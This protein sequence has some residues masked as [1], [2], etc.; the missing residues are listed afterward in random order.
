[1][2][3]LTRRDYRGPFGDMVDWLEAPW[4]MLRPAT[5]HL[6]RVEDL[7]KDGSYVVRAELPGIDPEKDVEVTVARGHPDDQGRAARRGD[8][9]APLRVPLRQLHPQRDAA[10]AAPTRS[11]STPST[12]T[13]SWK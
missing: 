4:T 5:G 1:M 11:T 9:Q 10:G 6:M 8:R 3:T 7:V 2:S 13:A 12:A